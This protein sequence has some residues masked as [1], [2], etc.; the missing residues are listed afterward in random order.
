MGE[1]SE[2]NKGQKEVLAALKAIKDG[3]FAWFRANRA[4]SLGL[5][6]GEEAQAEAVD[7]QDPE[8]ALVQGAFELGLFCKPVYDLVSGPAQAYI[9][10]WAIKALKQM[11]EDY[12]KQRR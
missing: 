11:I 3:I 12:F 7:P 4:L 5:R 10:A 9:A 2:L 8:L 6:E 1:D